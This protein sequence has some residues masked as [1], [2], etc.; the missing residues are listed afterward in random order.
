MPVDFWKVSGTLVALIAGVNLHFCGFL[1]LLLFNIL[2]G[3]T[4]SHFCVFVL[5]SLFIDY[6][7]ASCDIAA[8]L[9]FFLVLVHDRK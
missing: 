1:F 5:Y 3:M 2:L 9:C 7:L 6:F 8:I 4:P